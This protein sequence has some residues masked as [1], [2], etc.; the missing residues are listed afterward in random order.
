M[1]QRGLKFPWFDRGTA[2]SNVDVLGAHFYSIALLG[3][4]TIVV[5]LFF[6]LAASP[7]TDTDASLEC[8]ERR[9]RPSREYRRG[10][11]SFATANADA[12]R[13][14]P[15]A[16]ANFDDSPT[17]LRSPFDRS[18]FRQI[19]PTSASWPKR[20]RFFPTT[21]SEVTNVSGCRLTTVDDQLCLTEH[22][23]WIDSSA[24]TGSVYLLNELE[25]P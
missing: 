13:E 22:G 9:A 25:E 15:A 5:L 4:R 8:R 6:S 3:V 1:A 14:T 24:T 12:F 11:S 21:L 16:V 18:H 20:F 17:L 23:V 2:S 10:L 7:A 19:S